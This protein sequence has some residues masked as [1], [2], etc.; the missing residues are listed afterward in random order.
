MNGTSVGIT[1]YAEDLDTVNNT[2]TYRLSDDSN[3]RFAIDSISG[4]VTLSDTSLVD[5]ETNTSHMI[6]VQALSSDGSTNAQS[7]TIDV[8]DDPSDN[9]TL[10]SGTIYNDVLLGTENNDQF[11][12][13]GGSDIFRG[14]N[15]N[16]EITIND[17][18]NNFSWNIIDDI[19]SIK[20]SEYF[21]KYGDVI[22][23]AEDVE[24]VSFYNGQ[25]DTGLINSDEDIIFGT[26]SDDFLIASDADERIDGIGGEDKIDGGFGE[27]TL[28]IFENDQNIQI[29]TLNG[30]TR[31]VS[32]EESSEYYAQPSKVFG[33]ETVKLLDNTKSI[34]NG[35]TTTNDGNLCSSHTRNTSK[36]NT[37]ST[38]VFL[39]TTG[40]DLCCHSAGNF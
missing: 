18:V 17:S 31:I 29:D 14:F 33:I 1:A 8:L 16:D 38:F 37:F 27:D 20:P 30:L 10:I 13:E 19:L 15:G 4:V 7:F 39:K 22:L 34:D 6:T 5:Y 21:Q 36:K 3:G 25:I 26:T 40:P 23:R 11:L 2:V 32:L 12:Y 9:I 35:N 28:Y 24:L